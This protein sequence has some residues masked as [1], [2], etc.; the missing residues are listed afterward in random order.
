MQELAKISRAA[1]KVLGEDKLHQGNLLVLDATTG[2]NAVSQGRLFA[3][4]VPLTGLVLNKL[5]GSA[6]G[7]VIFAVVAACGAPVLFAGVGET[8][9]DLLDFDARQFVSNLLA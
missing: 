6:R 2:Q 9:D 4:A 1:V 3:E 7:G 5:D 8:A